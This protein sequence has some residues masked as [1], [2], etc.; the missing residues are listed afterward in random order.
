LEETLKTYQLDDLQSPNIITRMKKDFGTA[1]ERLL[2][3][4]IPD[5]PATE[6]F[7]HETTVTNLL[8][9]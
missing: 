6:K 8:T 7:V 3:S 9:Q 4:L 2:R 1:V 5:R